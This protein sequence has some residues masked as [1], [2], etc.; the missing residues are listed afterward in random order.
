LII[1]GLVGSSIPGLAPVAMSYV[2]VV[3][4][5]GPVLTRFTGGPLSTRVRDSRV[6]AAG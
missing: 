3:A 2:F 4:V 5:V 6:P 1:I